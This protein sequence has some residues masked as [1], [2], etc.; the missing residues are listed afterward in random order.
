[1]GLVASVGGGGGAVCALIS[2]GDAPSSLELTIRADGDVVDWYDP[3][4]PGIVLQGGNE[5]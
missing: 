3:S 2:D 1:M 4:P 5:T